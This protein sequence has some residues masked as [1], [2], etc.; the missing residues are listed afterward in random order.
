MSATF[1]AGVI[2]TSGPQPS[3]PVVVTRPE[4]RPPVEVYAPSRLG[5]ERQVWWSWDTD[6]GDLAAVGD[7]WFAPV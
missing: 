1:P 4:P 5:G 6:P 7:L 3:G 2:V